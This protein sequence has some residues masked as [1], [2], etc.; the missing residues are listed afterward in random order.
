[1]GMRAVIAYE[2][3]DGTV[4]VTRNQWSTQLHNI[5]GDYIAGKVSRGVDFDKAASVLFRHIT[6]NE[7]VSAINLL[8]ENGAKAAKQTDYQKVLAGKGYESNMSLVIDG[9][10]VYDKVETYRNVDNLAEF[11]A[12]HSHAQDGVSMYYSE[13]NPGVIGFYLDDYYDYADPQDLDMAG[14]MSLIK[15]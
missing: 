2:K 13:K 15:G 4:K 12:N 8:D 9:T 14:V 3:A 10:G 7:H 6:E 5:V 1:M 11:V